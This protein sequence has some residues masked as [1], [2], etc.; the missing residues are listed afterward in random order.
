M[1]TTLSIDDDLY[2]RAKAAAALRGSSVTSF[3]EEALRR[4]LEAPATPAVV[5]DLPVARET[6]G[7]LPG[8]DLHDARA[9]AAVL[10]E[11]RSIDALR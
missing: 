10:D 2:R 7:P 8:I 1:R 3:I 11:G 6:C 9:L 4:S 5:P